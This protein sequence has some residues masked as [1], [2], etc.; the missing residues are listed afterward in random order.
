M[1]YIAGG[2]SLVIAIV[3]VNGLLILLRRP[4]N[5]KDKTVILPKFLLIIGIICS[6]VFLIPTVIILFLNESAVLL[7]AFTVFSLWGAS[8]I[9]AYYNCRIIY[10]ESTFTSKNF[11]GCKHTFTYNQITAI[12]GK[13]MDVKLYMGKRVVRIDALAVGKF[14]FLAFAKK[15][16]RKQN[17]GKAIPTA[18]AKAD[19]FNGNVEQ[20]G[21][22]IFVYVLIGLLCIGTM[23]VFAI[24]SAPRNADDLEYAT[25]AFE[26]YEIQDNKL[27]LYTSDDSTY[28]SVPAYEELLS[29]VNDFLNLCNSGEAFDVGYVIYDDAKAP[30][31]GLESIARIDGTIYLSMEVVHN[32][33]WG[34]AWAFYLI[35]GGL[36]VIWFAFVAISIY[37]GRN[38]EK[39]SRRFIRLFFKDGYV[40]QSKIKQKKN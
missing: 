27:L 1:Q 34:E 20:P 16:Y 8:L 6:G 17:N 23:A 32:Y 22:L 10:D 28:Y 25:L 35:F 11:F 12:Q 5:I 4:V 15:Q 30:H 18:T 14:E 31:Y 7:I 36:T 33:R 2:L 9:V 13:A 21:E 39:F 37:V 26:R 40:R 29:D 19:I 3:L 24:A 38:P